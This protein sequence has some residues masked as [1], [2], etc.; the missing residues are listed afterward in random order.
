MKKTVELFFWKSIGT[1]SQ[2]GWFVYAAKSM[3]W[4][5]RVNNI[6]VRK[7][8]PTNYI[9]FYFFEYVLNEGISTPRSYIYYKTP[10]PWLQVKCLRFLQ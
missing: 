7:K 2:L 6:Y 10:V 9:D 5:V 3:I 4:N 8:K 1:V